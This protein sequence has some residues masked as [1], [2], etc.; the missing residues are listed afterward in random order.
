MNSIFYLKLNN[1]HS[2][3][4]NLIRFIPK[5]VYKLILNMTY[6]IEMSEEIPRH[7]ASLRDFFYQ[8]D[9]LTIHYS[10]PYYNV[11][12]FYTRNAEPFLE[13]AKQLTHITLYQRDHKPWYFLVSHSSGY[14]AKMAVYLKKHPEFPIDPFLKRFYLYDHPIDFTFYDTL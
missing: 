6:E 13:K 7:V 3:I 4:M 11:F 5:S 12:C 10:F 9:E 2:S 14:Q 8:V 1:L